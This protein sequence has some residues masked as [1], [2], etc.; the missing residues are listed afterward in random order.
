MKEDENLNQIFTEKTQ[1]MRLGA[2][3]LELLNEPEI[4]KQYL[5]LGVYEPKLD[6]SI[7]GVEG[8][9]LEPFFYY[10][11]TIR[12]REAIITS[13]Q[14]LLRN[15]EEVFYDRVLREKRVIGTNEIKQFIDYG[16]YL[17]D[18]APTISKEAIKKFL[19]SDKALDKRAIFQQ[20]LDKINFYM[21]FGDDNS[22]A[23]VQACWVIATH[24]YPLF[25][26]F[27][28]ILFHAPSESGKSKNAF[29]LMQMSFRGFDLGAAAGV[30]PAQIFRTIE[31]NRGSLVIDEYEKLEKSETQQLV[32][33]I[34]NAS[35]TRDAYVIRTE[36][37]DKKW[38]AWKFP[39]FCPKIACSISGINPTSLNRF[40]VFQLLKT[41]TEKGKRKPNRQK[42]LESFVPLRD[43]IS[44]FILENWKEIRQIYE[45]L[46]LNL[47][48]R[49]ED[50][51]LPLCAVAKFIGEDVLKKVFEYIQTYQ[52]I[53]LQSNDV[54][55][56]FF[57]LLYEVV[58][59]E[60]K[61]YG[62]KELSTRAELSE[63]LNHLKSPAHWIGKQL[64]NRKFKRIIPKGSAKY[65]LSKKYVK[66]IID[67]YFPSGTEIIQPNITNTTNTTQSNLIQLKKE[68]IIENVGL[69]GVG[70]PV[71]E[72]HTTQF[73]DIV[74]QSSAI[75]LR[76]SKKNI[77]T[78]M[79]W[80]TASMS[81]QEA[82]EYLKKHLEA[83]NIYENSTGLIQV[84]E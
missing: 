50:N 76:D 21:D 59:D 32:N 56:E 83:G 5:D 68:E 79:A 46:D 30:T 58:D 77:D 71:Q 39:I 63:L 8:T 40:I 4:S 61:Y 69:G 38:R 37:I 15:T 9:E 52:D 66:N 7:K 45:S 78:I 27:P 82:Q 2:E 74:R 57:Y 25:Y 14:K 75:A 54:E 13:T 43:D 67:R 80:L 3:L 70:L 16:G 49:D 12:G 44:I 64:K 22:I 73:L 24:C 62:P 81:E 29:I 72:V 6:D 17:G 48:N 23:Y 84:L 53:K 51:W 10:G 20:V 36:Q 34:L 35:A 26:W 41:Q 33:Q 31:G 11:L 65:L 1:E 28:H 19:A 42:D 55:A 18:I 47:I 60:N